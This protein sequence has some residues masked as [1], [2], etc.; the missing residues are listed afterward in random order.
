MEVCDRQE[1]RQA[2]QE[3]KDRGLHLVD[4]MKGK[5]GAW[6]RCTLIRGGRLLI[7]ACCGRQVQWPL[8]A[9]TNELR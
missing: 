7:V 4:P 8:T 3:V 9:F 5:V 1:M 2:L 6:P